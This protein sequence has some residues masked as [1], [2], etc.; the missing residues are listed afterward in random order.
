MRK[1]QVQ[2]RWERAQRSRRGLAHPAVPVGDG[3]E[4]W[5]IE[6]ERPGCD[7]VFV[8][9]TKQRRYCSTECRDIVDITR[10]QRTAHLERMM[11]R[12]CDA[13]GCRE[14]FAAS[15]SQPTRRFCSATCRARAH[16]EAADLT[17]TTK[18]DACGVSLPSGSTRRRRYCNDAC[19]KRA[20]RRRRRDMTQ[21]KEI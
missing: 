11:T 21:K 12:L 4:D 20:E 5:E 13:P 10:G 3:S 9:P 19:R 14:T 16:V 2:L 7:K 15:V 18:C 1:T 8:T 6:C 17:S